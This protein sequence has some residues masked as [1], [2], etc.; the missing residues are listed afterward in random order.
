ML[1]FGPAPDWARSQNWQP[2]RNSPARP[3]ARTPPA[4]GPQISNSLANKPRHASSHTALTPAPAARPATWPDHHL[5]PALFTS[6]LFTRSRSRAR[7]LHGARAS[8]VHFV[9]VNRFACRPR[10]ERR[11]LPCCCCCCC[12]CASRPGQLLSRERAS[13]CLSWFGDVHVSRTARVLSPESFSP[14][15]CAKCLMYMR[16][17]GSRAPPAC[18]RR[19]KRGPLDSRRHR[20]RLVQHLCHRRRPLIGCPQHPQARHEKQY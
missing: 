9:R 14:G 3:L 2:A 20:A 5:R 19:P 7:N 6:G 1:D 18:A 8:G 12:C 17:P 10:L 11:C 4:S 13:G 15:S 16:A